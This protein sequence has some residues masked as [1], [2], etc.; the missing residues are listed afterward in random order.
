[1][2]TVAVGRPRLNDLLAEAEPNPPSPNSLKKPIKIH[3]HPELT[4]S[5]RVWWGSKGD[6]QL[7]LFTVFMVNWHF[8]FPSRICCLHFVAPCSLG[9]ETG[10]G[11]VPDRC[12]RSASRGARF[13]LGLGMIS[14]VPINGLSGWSLKE[15]KW[16]KG[17]SNTTLW[18]HGAHLYL[19]S[20]IRF[21]EQ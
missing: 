21:F 11:G 16:E 7:V 6:V 13:C 4:F 8:Q 10:A 12:H 2:C 14:E 5:L 9:P 20:L 19:Y 17:K 3:V 15:K 18:A 1:M